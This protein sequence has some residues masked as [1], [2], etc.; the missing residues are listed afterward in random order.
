MQPA[1]P[2]LDRGTF[3]EWLAQHGQAPETVAA[4]W[5]L[6]ALPTLNLRAGE[7][8]AALGAF[9]FQEGLLRHADA[10]D[11]GWAGAPLS[12]VHGWP[13]ER[14]LQEAG[15]EVRLGW[16]AQRVAATRGRLEVEAANGG[17]LDA[18][19]VIVA[20]PHQRVA[21]LL[22]DGAIPAPE[23]LAALGTSPIVN[24]HVVYD[25]RVTDLPFAAGVRSPVQYLFDRTPR[26]GLGDGLIDWYPAG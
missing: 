15:V 26:A 6:I 20:V 13:A 2:A 14:T 17:G 1:D 3:G 10:G 7:A 18:D 21:G 22:P 24:L 11:I 12:A 16:R 25:R 8:S 19:A 4:L 23:R 5:D 9:V